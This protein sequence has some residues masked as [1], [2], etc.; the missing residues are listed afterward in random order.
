MVSESPNS[1]SLSEKDAKPE[2]V[3][4]KAS[5]PIKYQIKTFDLNIAR[6]K[7]KHELAGYNIAVVSM[8]GTAD[9]FLNSPTADA[10]PLSAKSATNVCVGRIET[11]FSRFFLTNAQQT[12]KTLILAIGEENFKLIPK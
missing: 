12:G 8:D 4:K 1:P 2:S 7:Q 5:R 11:H 10:I 9:L 6:T 3:V